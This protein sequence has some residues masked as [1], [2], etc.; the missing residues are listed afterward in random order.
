MDSSEED[1]CSDESMMSLHCDEEFPWD[2]VF[3]WLAPVRK[4]VEN[5]GMWSWSANADTNVLVKSMLAKEE[6]ERR[7]TQ[8]ASIPR[9][10]WVLVADYENFRVILLIRDK[11]AFFIYPLDSRCD[12]LLVHR[13][14]NTYYCGRHESTREDDNDNINNTEFKYDHFISTHAREEGRGD[15]ANASVA[16]R[17]HYLAVTPFAPAAFDRVSHFDGEQV[18]H[19]HS[20]FG[21]SLGNGTGLSD[22]HSPRLYLSSAWDGIPRGDA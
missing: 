21:V 14:L 12:W 15:Q 18:H 9:H 19:V 20:A 2:E 1:V 22:T 16:S 8:V 3:P 10:K 5:N 13:T 4:V 6:G 17:G 11:P 7:M